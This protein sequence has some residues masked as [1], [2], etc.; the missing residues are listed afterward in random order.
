VVAALGASR[1]SEAAESSP[2]SV[3]LSFFLAFD[4]VEPVGDFDA[5]RFTI[6]AHMS[7]ETG[8]TFAC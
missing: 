7:A 4:G 1:D 6:T 8:D 3:F 5:R 2:S